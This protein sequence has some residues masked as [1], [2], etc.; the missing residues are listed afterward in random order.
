MCNLLDF[1]KLKGGIKNDKSPD[2]NNEN[3][4]IMEEIKSEIADPKVYRYNR[5]LW[6]NY[7]GVYD[8]DMVDDL[9]KIM[10]RQI[11][12]NIDYIKRLNKEFKLINSF[13]FSQVFIQVYHILKLAGD[14]PHIIRGSAGS[15]LLCYLMRIT[16]IDPILEGIT[17]SRFM[18]K[19]RKDIPDIDIDFPSDKRDNIYLRIFNYW[20]NRVARISNHI[21]YCEKSAY[22]EAIREQGYRKFL[23]RDFHLEDIFNSQKQIDKVH[24]RVREMVGSFRCYSLH[25]GGIVI[26]KDK[27]PADI[28]LKQFNIDND[29]NI[30]AQI[31]LNKD[32]VE[33]NGYIKIDIL[34]NRGLT[35]L[36]D[37]CKIPIDNYTI[38]DEK[39]FKIFSDG[40]NIGITHSESRAMMKVFRTIKPRTI[41]DIAI[42]LALI[43][44]AAAKGKQKSEFLVDYTPFKYGT[45]KFIIFDDDATMF[46]KG[47][48]GCSDAD[49]DNYRRA[50]AKNREDGK[51]DF[52]EKL[53]KKGLVLDEYNKIIE[54]L[55]QLQYYSFCKSHA[56]SYAKLVWALAYHKANNIKNFWISAL[57][58]C[59]TSYRKWVHYREAIHAGVKIEPGY[60]PYKLVGDKLVPTKYYKNKYMDPVDQLINWGYWVGKD[61]IKGMYWEEYW[62]KLTK[63]NKEYDNPHKYS[64]CKDNHIKMAKF[65]GLILTGK[66]HKRENAKGFITFL[67]IATEDC[68]YHDLILYGYHKVSNMMCVSGHGKIRDDGICKWIEVHKFKSEW[69]SSD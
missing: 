61:F 46:I 56:Y 24:K 65:K 5:R 20:K 11:P 16:D 68:V 64:I 62:S 57:N 25:C 13:Q 4:E 27:V 52:C 3:N 43:R 19:S 1:Y 29:G 23:P 35:Q 33:D 14:I 8:N 59:N 6:S 12:D 36:W 49:A 45:E 40:N 9:F 32:E 55:D 47:L 2:E 53:K 48:L 67:T 15:C 44:P 38:D 63:K 10:R 51:N 41:K 34:S 50:F 31:K 18:H 21:M 30:G 7:D 42:A 28:M 66:G 69:L 22:R 54:R 26:F 37:I 60:K 17:L 39:T 58:N